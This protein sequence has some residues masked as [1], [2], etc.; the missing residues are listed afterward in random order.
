MG[1][2]GTPNMPIFAYKA[3]ADEISPIADTD[4]LVQQFCDA[5]VSIT[6]VRDS[7]G[8]HF[9]QAASSVGDILNFLTA[10]FNGVP[11]TGCE[12]RNSYLDAL[13][14]GAP[15]TLVPVYAQV[16]LLNSLGVPV[17]PLSV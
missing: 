7:F 16:L 3:V 5:G 6:Y 10:R 14:A 12:V 4:K 17:G 13:D 15:Q 8:E 11:I 1:T 2:H 9:T